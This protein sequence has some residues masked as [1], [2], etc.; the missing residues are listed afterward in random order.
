VPGAALQLQRGGNPAK[1]YRLPGKRQSWRCLRTAAEPHGESCCGERGGK[2]YPPALLVDLSQ[3]FGGPVAGD[4]AL[5]HPEQVVVAGFEPTDDFFENIETDFLAVEIDAGPVAD[6]DRRLALVDD[7]REPAAFEVFG[8]VFIR[9]AGLQPVPAAEPVAGAADDRDDALR[10]V[11]VKAGCVLNQGSD[12][13]LVCEKVAEVMR[14]LGVEYVPARFE[15]GFS[16][17]VAVLAA[18]AA[19]RRNAFAVETDILEYSQ[20]VGHVI[21][22]LVG[23]L[24]LAPAVIFYVVAG[25]FG[26]RPA[27]FGVDDP[28]VAD[29][30]RVDV[31]VG[32]HKLANKL[33]AVV[34]VLLRPAGKAAVQPAD[35]G[36]VG[37][38]AV[39]ALDAV[40]A[41]P[42]A[43]LAHER[44]GYLAG[45]ASPVLLVPVRPG[46]G[47]VRDA[48]VSHVH[49][50]GRV[51][52]NQADRHAVLR[53]EH[54]NVISPARTQAPGLGA[55]WCVVE[56]RGRASGCDCCRL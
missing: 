47:E 43:E 40:L 41:A 11:A 1:F 33:E 18:E 48:E 23:G 44:I 53:I 45:Q 15:R 20:G 6:E 16:E 24:V 10:V 19:G 38:Y 25:P 31:P 50:A 46:R 22:Q 17:I 39:L 8:D 3:L 37:D 52:D 9:R 7:F 27:G 32:H 13:M 12:T 14:N 51:V 34:Q 2:C 4:L 30:L 42:L 49:K 56:G 54:G 36:R 35:T 55:R 21:G 5:F 28:G 29:H 26:I